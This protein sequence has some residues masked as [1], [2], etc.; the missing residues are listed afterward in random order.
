VPV[1][2]AEAD[3]RYSRG[4][5]EGRLEFAQVWIDNADQLNDALTR[6][7][8]VDPHRPGAARV[9]PAEGGYRFD[10]GRPVRRRRRVPRFENFDTQYRMASAG[11]RCRSSIGTRGSS[12]PLLARPRYRG[13]DRLYSIVRNRSAVHRGPNSFNLGLGWWF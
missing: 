6:R 1:K 5:F 11:V 9:L 4:R 12:A 13:Q 3:A 7:V 2:L 8:G 10:R